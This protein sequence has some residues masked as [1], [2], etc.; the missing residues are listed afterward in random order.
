MTTNDNNGPRLGQAAWMAWR[1][2]GHAHS[3]LGVAI[4]GCTEVTA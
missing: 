3:R 2:S 4:V 1:S